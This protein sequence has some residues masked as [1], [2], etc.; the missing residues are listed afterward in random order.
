MVAWSVRDIQRCDPPVYL[1]SP[2]F[3]VVI[4]LLYT[5]HRKELLNMQNW[6]TML[7]DKAQRPISMQHAQFS[8]L[9]QQYNLHLMDLNKLEGR[10]KW[11]WE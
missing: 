1:H 3:L 11:S 10:A 8:I 9:P 5:T 7:V 4:I 6:T 2:S